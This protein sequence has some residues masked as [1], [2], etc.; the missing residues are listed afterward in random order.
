MS[1]AAKSPSDLSIDEILAT[2]RRIISEDEQAGTTT[3]SA[4]VPAA[5]AAEAPSGAAPSAMTASTSPAAGTPSGGVRDAVARQADDLDDVLELTEAINEDGTTR[6]L[7]PIGRSTRRAAASR[8]APQAT[9]A[10]RPAPPPAAAPRAAPQQA[11]AAPRLPQDLPVGGGTRTLEDIVGDLLRPMLQ[12]W[13][14]ENLSPLV[15]RMVQAEI[16][17]RVPREAG[18]S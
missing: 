10:P 15:D 11:A 5:R 6:H 18:S 2:I 17:R 3:A 7:A 12:A 4:P 1:D 14:D 8:P 13:L 16:A 9:A